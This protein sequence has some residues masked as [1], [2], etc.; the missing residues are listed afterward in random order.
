MFV[1]CNFMEFDKLK[2]NEFKKNRIYFAPDEMT[3]T[4]KLNKC[5]N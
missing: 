5:S 4:K 2:S 1:L 3:K